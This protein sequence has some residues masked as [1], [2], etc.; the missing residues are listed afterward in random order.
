[1]SLTTSLIPLL[2]AL[3]TANPTASASATPALEAT[4]AVTAQAQ[5]ARQDSAAIVAVIHAFH[6]ALHNRD[7]ATVVRLLASNAQVAEGGGLETR[8]EYLSHHLPG[9]MAYAAAVTR[10]V[11]AMSVTISGDMA[12]AMST[13]H[14][15]GAVGERTI[16]SNGVELMVLVRQ[17]GQWRISAVH[18]SS[19]RRG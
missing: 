16:D 17:N 12:W 5:G 18:W 8:A 6:D 2:T 7:T 9:D 13:T 15:T 3:F 4:T 19:Q 11:T 10:A 14:T 1:M